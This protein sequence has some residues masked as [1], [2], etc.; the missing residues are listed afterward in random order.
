MSRLSIALALVLAAGWSVPLRAET[1]WTARAGLAASTADLGTTVIDPKNKFGFG[2]G[3][4]V[5]WIFSRP[6]G[7]QAEALYVPKGVSLGESEATD[8]VGNS[9]GTFETFYSAD[10]LEVPL[11]LR[12]SP[13]TAGVGFAVTAGPAVAFELSDRLTTRGAVETEADRDALDGVDLGAC[14]GAELLVPF[15]GGHTLVGARYTH[16]LL[17]LAAGEREFRNR[18]FLVTLGYAFGGER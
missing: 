7:V 17:D 6:W 2:G 8:E 16:G 4:G 18:A 10:Y 11:L 15:A 13:V 3:L 14:V 5:T 9:I 12:Y 1:L